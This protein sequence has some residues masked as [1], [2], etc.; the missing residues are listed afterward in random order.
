MKVQ[1]DLRTEPS[2]PSVTQ[3]ERIRFEHDLK[4]IGR[5]VMG[6]G[7]TFIL[8][9]NRL[10]CLYVDDN[11]NNE[12]V[13]QSRRMGRTPKPPSAAP[14]RE[15]RSSQQ[16]RR[17]RDVNTPKTAPQTPALK[18][19]APPTRQLETETQILDISRNIQM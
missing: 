4:E 17:H 7:N 8:T 1:N 6:Y 14:R 9:L 11:I 12:A 3:T 19:R 13:Y 5:I 15:L 16:F 10:L 18:P 2:L